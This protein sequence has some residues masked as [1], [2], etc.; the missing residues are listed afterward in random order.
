MRYFCLIFLL[1]QLLRAQDGAAIYKQRCAACHDNPAPHAPSLGTIKAM[2]GRAIYTALTS[3]VMKT[4]AAGL[5]TAQKIAL[6]R[7]I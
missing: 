4:Q 2:S 3:G 7:Y 1:A 5:S 6:I